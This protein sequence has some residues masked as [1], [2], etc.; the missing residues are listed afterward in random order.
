MAHQLNVNANTFVPATPP[1][2]PIPT[3]VPPKKKNRHARHSRA[4]RCARSQKKKLE[5]GLHKNVNGHVLPPFSLGNSK[6]SSSSLLLPHS[7]PYCKI[8]SSSYWDLPQR[9]HPRAWTS[10]SGIGRGAE[11]GT[12]K[13]QGYG[14]I[15]HSDPRPITMEE[16]EVDY[17]VEKGYGVGEWRRAEK[18]GDDAGKEDLGWYQAW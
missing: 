10:V 7:H 12:A 6:S 4:W 1:N 8:P 16:G 2:P 17:V 9:L 14:G 13:V 5:D 18:R 15:M 3:R 11:W